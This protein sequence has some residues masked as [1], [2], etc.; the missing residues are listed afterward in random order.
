MSSSYR[1][2]LSKRCGAATYAADRAIVRLGESTSV[3]ERRE[4]YRSRVQA[5]LRYPLSAAKLTRNDARWIDRTEETIMVRMGCIERSPPADWRER[6]GWRAVSVIVAEER[7]LLLETM[8]N[9]PPESWR[10]YLCPEQ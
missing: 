7:S 4:E 1:V 6:M 9:S 8:K 10:R 3:A 2:A 5:V